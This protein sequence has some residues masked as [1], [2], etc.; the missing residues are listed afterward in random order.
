MK[1]KNIPSETAVNP[2]GRALFYPGG[3]EAVLIIH[4]FT[5]RTSEMA[6]L[7]GTLNDRGYTVSVPRLPG[8]GT[9]GQDF[10]QTDR[11]QWLRHVIDS[12]LNLRLE[13]DSVHVVGLSMGG[14]LAVLLA[15]RFRPSSLT[16][17]APALL[18]RR[19][20]IVLTPIVG[21]FISHWKVPYEP[22][23]EDPIER[24]LQ[25][26]YYAYQWVRPA[27]HLYALM[28]QARRRLP[29][30]DAPTLTVI[31]EADKMVPPSVADLIERC[32]ATEQ[33]RRLRLAE[34]DH[35]L[36]NGVDREQVAEEIANWLSVTSA[37]V[38]NL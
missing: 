17:C 37:G 30:V 27:A 29:E 19:K 28:R 2:F 13:Y 26:E 32:V 3:S 23:S 25:L 20:N 8:H 1:L 14:V 10:L 34:S 7:A 16:L 31:S 36:V 22:D 11:H 9:N 12:Y 4:G 38:R 33:T 6:F 15:S 21:R 35:V 5:G 18:L 24:E